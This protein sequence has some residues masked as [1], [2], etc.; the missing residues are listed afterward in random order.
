VSVCGTVSHLL[1][2]TEAIKAAHGAIGNM[3]ITADTGQ[4]SLTL[5]C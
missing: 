5:A 4:R 3:G 2:C 1:D